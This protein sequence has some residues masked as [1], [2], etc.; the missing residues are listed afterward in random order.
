MTSAMFCVPTY[1]ELRNALRFQAAGFN[2]QNPS[3]NTRHRNVIISSLSPRERVRV[4]AYAPPSNNTSSQ[5]LIRR[6]AHPKRA[7]G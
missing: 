7:S 6:A 2:L 4:R 5:R 1:N 3:M